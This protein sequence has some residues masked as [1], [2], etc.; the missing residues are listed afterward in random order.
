MKKILTISFLALLFLQACKKD[1]KLIDNLKPEERASQELK[2]YYNE[3]TKSPNGWV[4]YL[5]TTSVKGLYSFYLNF[6]EDNSLT[7]KADFSSNSLNKEQAST[8]RLKKV[9]ASTLI[10]DTDSYINVL[11]DP[12]S[13]MGGQRGLGFGSD[14]EFEIQEQIADTI[15][16][17]GKRRGASLKLVK[18]TAAD[19]DYYAKDET[20]EIVDY[21]AKNQLLYIFDEQD[22][23]KKIQVSFNMDITD[24]NVALS[25]L[26]KDNTISSPKEPF[27]FSLPGLR[28]NP[29]TFGKG[30]IIGFEW[31]KTNKKIFAVTNS[32]Q[33]IELLVS[34][35]PFFPL[36]LLVGT[37]YANITVPNKTSYPGWGT[38]FISRRAATATAVFNGGYRLLLDQ[39]QFQFDAGAQKLVLVVGIPQQ[40]GGYYVANFGY[41]YTKTANGVFKFNAE[42][43]Y[44]GNANLIKTQMKALLDERLNTDTFT[45]DYFIDPTS[46]ALLGQ[47]KSIEHPDF[48]FAGTL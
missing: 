7:L 32:G 25:S 26:N 3:L 6:K 44:K 23:N 48:T 33:K 17:I 20:I 40:G 12:R 35:R 5:N 31:D 21:I 29:L 9:T 24:R 22:P 28:N 36:H 43:T 45:I 10:F 14:S 19:K 41:S 39:M 34:D 47:L 2:H 46:K 1:L 8:Y 30:S 27:C 13:P 16:L 42:P 37:K 4:A 38:D 18:A 11:H 15:K